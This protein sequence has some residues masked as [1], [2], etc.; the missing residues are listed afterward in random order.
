MVNWELLFENNVELIFMH[1][2]IIILSDKIVKG[3]KISSTL[4]KNYSP[5]TEQVTKK[6]LSEYPNSRIGQ[7]LW[8]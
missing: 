1:T 3:I 8:K 2:T 7:E 4:C 6:F 5:Y